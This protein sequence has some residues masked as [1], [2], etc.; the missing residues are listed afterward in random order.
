MSITGLAGNAYP[1]TASVQVFFA[2]GGELVAFILGG[3][4]SE[5]PVKLPCPRK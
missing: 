4:I 3:A 5:A 2:P 1:E